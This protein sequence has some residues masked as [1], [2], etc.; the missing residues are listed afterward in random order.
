MQLIGLLAICR[1]HKQYSQN[2]KKLFYLAAQFGNIIIL[3]TWKANNL[4]TNRDIEDTKSRT[5]MI[6]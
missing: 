2:L 1:K 6:A 4:Y 3:K 5:N